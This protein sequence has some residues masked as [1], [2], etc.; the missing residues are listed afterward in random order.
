MRP[1][2]CCHWLCRQPPALSSRKTIWLSPF[3]PRRQFPPERRCWSGVVPPAWAVM[4]FSSRQLPGMKSSQWPL[5][6]ITTISKKIGAVEVFDYRST[7]VVPDIILAFRNR[8]AAGAVS[9]GPGSFKKCIDIL[10][11]C[12]GNKF[13]AQATLDMPAFPKGALDFPPFIVSTLANMIS[14]NIR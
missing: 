3:P 4:P 10:G 8:L 7:T 13:I 2:A 11:G 14:G 12:K 1:R 5:R 6:K 9:I